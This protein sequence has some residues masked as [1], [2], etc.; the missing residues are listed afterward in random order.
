MKINVKK[1]LIIFVFCLV[2]GG[3]LWLQ[4]SMSASIMA[5]RKTIEDLSKQEATLKGAVSR[6]YALLDAYRDI[7]Q[8]VEAF[9]FSFPAD[10]V[11]FFPDFI[12]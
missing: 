1:A 8:K 9:Q 6:K 12:T 11:A 2:V 7:L 10:N 4:H 3:F 5:E